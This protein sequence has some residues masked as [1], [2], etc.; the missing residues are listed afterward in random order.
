MEAVAH[1]SNVI[2][3]TV[4]RNVAVA[5]KFG[6]YNQLADHLKAPISLA[7]ER[8][9]RGRTLQAVCFG[10]T[11]LYLMTID[12]NAREVGSI[13]DEKDLDEALLEMDAG[14]VVTDPYE[15]QLATKLI[16]KFGV[17]AG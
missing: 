7:W 16:E 2:T 6:K 9:K 5:L 3:G 10:E 8:L 17:R 12:P 1:D 11:T 13:L 4:R 14:R 15:L